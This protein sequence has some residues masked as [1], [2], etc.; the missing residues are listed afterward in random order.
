MTSAICKVIE[1][2]CRT[3]LAP[4]F[5]SLARSVLIDHCFTSSGS[6][7]VRRKLARLQNRVS[8]Q[9]GLRAEGDH[10]T[11]A[12]GRQEPLA[13]PINERLLVAVAHSKAAVPLTAKTGHQH[14][15]I[16]RVS[17]GATQS[18]TDGPREANSWPSGDHLIEV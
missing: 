18:S 12:L 15:C 9:S 2:P 3:T 4:I 17:P 6:A 13:I 8:G 14:R 16:P 11:V 7:S 5:T 10:P 1:R